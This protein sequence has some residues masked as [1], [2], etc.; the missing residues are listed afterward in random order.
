MPQPFNRIDV[1]AI[2]RLKQQNHI[3]WNLQTLGSMHHRVIKL[4]QVQLAWISLSKVAQKL[5]KAAA[6]KVSSS[7]KCSPLKGSTTP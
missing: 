1:W 3:A 2:G 5:L 4:N 7:S 6:I